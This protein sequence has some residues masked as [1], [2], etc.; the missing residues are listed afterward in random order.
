MTNFN[1]SP[2]PFV[3]LVRRCLHFET[4]G[5]PF[6]TAGALCAPV[7]SLLH[8]HLACTV[9]KATRRETE[10]GE[11]YDEHRSQATDHHL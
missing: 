4:L 6:E 5:N 7:T 10:H 1:M 3:S 9:D 8:W 11:H 2:P